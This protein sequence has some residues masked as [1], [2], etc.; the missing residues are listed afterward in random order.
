M[1]DT[2]N[3]PGS[4]TSVSLP[5]R[6]VAPPVT[7]SIKAR[8][9]LSDAVKSGAQAHASGHPDPSDIEAW[10]KLID[11]TN[12]NATPAL[13][14]ILRETRSHIETV[15]IARVTCYV[16]TPPQ[17]P[18]EAA[19]RVYLFL[20]GGALL[21]GSGLYAKAEAAT[22]ADS[23][24]IETISVDYRMPPDHP[25]PA[26]P[27]DCV[28]VYRELLK[29]HAPSD[30][31]LGGSSAGGNI[32]AAATLMIRDH[33]LPL[34]RALVLL[35]PEADLTE[36]GDTFQTNVL[37]DVTLKRGLTNCNALYA[38]AHD[39]RD[40]Y[41]SPLFG[42]FSAG[43]PPTLIQSGTR[44]LFLSN[45]VMLHRKL[46]RAGIRAELHV[47]EAMPHVAFGF[48]FGDAPENHEVDEEVRSFIRH[49][50]EYV[51]FG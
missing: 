22:R 9:A 19:K 51:Y 17:L 25:F 50:F 39:L 43:F 26:A 24:G 23:L 29:S 15:T 14:K 16:A 3:S 6:E 36:S 20:H 45:S 37:V 10:R 8:K 31:I 21:F 5:A 34:P 40:P 42:D 32:A 18:A 41:V 35:S 47:W 11:T 49:A 12:S 30:M 2:S 27:E 1:T 7:I 4:L 38:G 13:E 46:R 44:G 28:A 33:G 48:G